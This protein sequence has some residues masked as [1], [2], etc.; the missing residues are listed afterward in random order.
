MLSQ[1]VKVR[2]NIGAKKMGENDQ[3]NFQQHK[4]KHD[5]L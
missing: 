1:I 2:K 3:N 4:S 5:E